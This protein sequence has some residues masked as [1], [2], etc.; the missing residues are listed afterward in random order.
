[1]K[2]KFQSGTALLLQVRVIRKPPCQHPECLTVG[3]FAECNNRLVLHAAAAVPQRLR[4]A[5]AIKIRT[6][7]E[8]QRRTRPGP[9]AISSNSLSESFSWKERRSAELIKL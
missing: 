4:T 7:S 9:D 1:M 8:V 2:G 6:E 5:A 3:K